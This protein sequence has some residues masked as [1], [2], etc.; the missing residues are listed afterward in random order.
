[1]TKRAKFLCTVAPI[2]ILSG[3]AMA[4]EK[5]ESQDAGTGTS[6]QAS[7]SLE[8][9][10][11][12]AQRREEVSSKVPLSVT[13]FG[14]EQLAERSITT[15]RDLQTSVPGLVVKTVT[16]E[17]QLTYS[18]RAQSVEPFSGVS[19][20]VLAYTNE[21]EANTGAPGSFYDL[22]S[23]Q[24]LKGPQG[25]L[26]GRNTTGGAILYTTTMP[27]ET[28]GGY[29]T[30]RVG[31]LGMLESLGAVDLPLSEA[32]QLRLAG[33]YYSRDGYQKNIDTGQMLGGSTRSSGRAT[34]VLRPTERL[35]NKT[36]FEDTSSHGH[37]TFVELYSYNACGA[38]G[39]LS[40]AAC[41]YGPGL[42]SVFGPGAWAAYLAAHPGANPGG[43]PAALA[44]QKQNPREVDSP[45]LSD[46]NARSWY[47]DNMTSFDV[48]DAL[49]IKNIFGYSDSRN[50]FS[51]DEEGAPFTLEVE[52]RDPVNG[53]QGNDFHDSNVTDE[54][55]VV[56]KAPDKNLD[57]VL[58]LYYSNA[59][60]HETAAAEYFDLAPVVP[61][62]VTTYAF[63]SKSEVKAVYGQATYD[64]SSLTGINGLKA[65]GGFRY[66][67]ERN[68]LIYPNIPHTVFG[69]SP[70]ESELF[71][72]PSWQVGLDYQVAPELMLYV[73]SRGSW[74]SGGFNGFAASNPT[75]AGLGGGNKFLPETTKDVEIG[76]KYRSKPLGIPT[77]LDIA[78]YSQ[79]I[80][81]VQKVS[82]VIVNG[83]P[84]GFTVNI[85]SAQVQGVEVNASIRPSQWLELGA[86]GAYTDAA[87]TNGRAYV[88]G[89]GF[90]TFGPFADVA[91]WSGTAYAQATLP[92]PDAWGQMSLRGDLYGQS[93]QYFSNLNN[94]VNPG[95]R[96]PGYSL[97]NLRFDWRRVAGS[98]VTLSAFAKNVTDKVYYTGGFA[99][100]DA[101]GTNAARV[102]E[103]RTFGAEL[104]YKF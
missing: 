56:G 11:V 102:A 89:S 58:G 77:S 34:L 90:N 88:L 38:P 68:T 85:P 98:N 36:I 104:T 1:M 14:A 16:S 27:G 53:I 71:Q 84:A 59:S 55:Q 39:L 42:D 21:V 12:T 65:T 33:D 60:H 97:L 4:Q 95:T 75:L 79:W 49:T 30:Q 5:S 54:F 78:A 40:G 32:V 44:W 76:A 48:S 23:V 43:I 28:L 9:V 96:L 24:V 3:A 67:W 19:P 83:S 57:Y 87:F 7:A 61:T 100:G 94:T 47:I 15:E 25:T 41:L 73:V 2:L 91:R 18:I 70:T 17:T 20:A 6:H 103:P 31:N 86:N 51:V 22:S 80:D 52:A 92:T 8:E 93:V 26:F 66:T 63:L 82:Y 74:R 101:F 81:N 35:E 10:V 64:L 62:S 50:H 69:G 99:V 37:P 46:F 45:Q 29:V 13:A 72:D